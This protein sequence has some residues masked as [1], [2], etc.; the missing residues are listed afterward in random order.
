MTR[1]E[2][3][4]H[5]H[6]GHVHTHAHAGPHRHLLHPR[7]SGGAG[8]G[9]LANAAY[10]RLYA[11]QV[12]ALV[13]SGVTT[14]AL[15]LLA[16]ALAG[17]DA[18]VVLGVALALK[19]V[20]YVGLSPV[21]AA[22]A[23]RVDRRRLLIT[24]DVVRALV[25]FALPFVTAVWQV[26]VLI[27]VVN[28]CAAGFTPA[29][30]ATIP[31]VLP[32]EE[33]YTRALSLSRI[34]YDLGELLSPVAAAALLLLV[35]FDALFAING[36]AFGLS[37]ALIAGVTLPDRRRAPA[38]TERTWARMTLGARRFLTVPRLRGLLALNLAAACASAMVIVNTVV[39]VRDEL[40]L[41]SSA[42]AIAL[43]AAGLGSVVVAAATP[44]L[45]RRVTDRTAML[46]G[47]LT[48]ALTLPLVERLDG[49][50]TLLGLWLVL[51]AG[52][53][54]VQTPVGR[55]LR[56]STTVDELP[57]LFAAQFALSH[58]CW[59]VTYPVAGVLGAAIGIGA[60]GALLGATSLV[61]ALLA[62]ALWRDGER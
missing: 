20:A 55:L 48:L 45:L 41:G 5:A 29:F 16:Y 53:A 39:L 28:A 38:G 56:R 17:D 33:D 11:A 51:G 2:P 59:L 13:G 42:V 19:M 60:V 34:A 15:G 23:H 8:A 6:G 61:A 46:G 12:V 18:G 50:A 52:L 10:R 57:E 1:R 7:R 9:P 35:D 49:F 24:L 44:A 3:L 47:A 26:F 36:V 31:Q 30:Q 40:G 43:G 62:A 25:L 22:V 54:L 4:P 21:I 27:F 58:A 32:D 14:V 37:A